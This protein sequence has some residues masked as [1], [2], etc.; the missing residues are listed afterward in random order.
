M[1]NI[2]QKQV[3]LLDLIKLKMTNE[4]DK[5]LTKT[6]VRFYDD[7]LPILGLSRSHLFSFLST[8]KKEKVIK[9]LHITNHENEGLYIDG[10]F[11]PYLVL[12]PEQDPGIYNFRLNKK[13]FDYYQ[14]TKKREYRQTIS[15]I[16]PIDLP[17]DTKWEDIKI[18]FTNNYDIKIKI[19]DKIIESDYAD[20]G[21]A[22]TRANNIEVT[23]AIQSWKML[24]LLAVNDGSLLLNESKKENDKKNKQ[25]NEIA[26]KLKTKFPT[27][28]EK[29]FVLTNN[30]IAEY[31]I[32]LELTPTP[33]F[34]D[35]YRDTIRGIGYE[36]PNKSYLPD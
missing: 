15:N 22:D 9:D 18:I 24:R 32:K 28:L 19:G 30:P 12:G 2:E 5:E 26:K 20:M 36:L 16:N 14:K 21:F 11:V 4:K 35:D 8:L 29:P 25:K 1:F 3:E 23:R 7:D 6:K 34:R 31:K 33:E 10:N 13:F 27:I 17:A